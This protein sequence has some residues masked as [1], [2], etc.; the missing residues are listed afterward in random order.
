MRDR[1]VAIVG[2]DRAELLDIAC[3]TTTLGMANHMGAR[4]PYR[5]VVATP[6]GRP[7]E[8][9]SG[10]T[11]GGQQSLERLS[12][13]LDTLIVAGGLGHEDAAADLRLVGH[14]RR[15]AVL[16]RRVASVCTGANVLAAAGLLDGRRVTTHWAFADGIA[17]R[18]PKVTV[19]PEPIYIRDG[20]VATS[21]GVTSA[22]DLALAFVEEDHGADV[23]RRVSRHLVTYLQRP[24][25][26]AQMSI[27]TA[28]P[29]PDNDIVRRMVDY[30]ASHL[31]EDLSTASLAAHAGIGQ[32]HL[33]RLFTHHTGQSA[34][35]YVRRA[36]AEAAANLLTSTSLPVAGVAR[37][38]GF[39]SAE[40]LRLAFAQLYGTS[41]SQY[42]TTQGRR[43]AR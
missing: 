3:I 17:A 10:L 26:Q 16:T 38:C 11:L 35:Q 2:Y 12:G 39:G 22:L 8:L 36:R 43:S 33:N 37:R 30:V 5:A 29:P 27:F 13:P 1:I 21:G 15:L 23:A 31:D 41:P 24:G 7:I 32:R 25:S 20:N 9:H 40:A 4:R 19:D 18:Y 14:V 42:R 34:G 28:A 6:G